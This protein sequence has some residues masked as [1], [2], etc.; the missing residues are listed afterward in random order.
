[1]LSSY[2]I[3]KHNYE[4]LLH[5]M[6]L[7]E[8]GYSAVSI[9]QVRLSVCR[10]RVKTLCQGL[11]RTGRPAASAFSA[12]KNRLRAMILCIFVALE[13]KNR[14]STMI[15]CIFVALGG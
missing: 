1:M 7:L 13:P 14:L 6:H 5:Y 11:E 9:E 2:S 4:Q 12:S 8:K 3:M 10:L 15:L